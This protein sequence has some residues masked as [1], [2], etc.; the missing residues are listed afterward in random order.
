MTRTEKALKLVAKGFSVSFAARTM[1][2][3]RTAIYKALSKKVCPKCGQTLKVKDR[4]A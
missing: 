1:E 3:S 4:A 2:I